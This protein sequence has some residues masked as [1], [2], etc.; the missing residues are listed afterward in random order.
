MKVWKTLS[1]YLMKVHCIPWSFS[2]SKS[3]GF[4]EISYRI[5]SFMTEIWCFTRIS[6][7][8]T[9][10]SMENF[11]SFQTDIDN[12]N[13]YCFLGCLD[14][15]FTDWVPWQLFWSIKA[16]NALKLGCVVK[17]RKLLVTNFGLYLPNFDFPDVA[18][19]HKAL[20]LLAYWHY[21][22]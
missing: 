21:A 20:R 12:D 9:L 17:H 16:K 10:L 3:L 13:S 4:Y 6:Q 2:W 14:T 5:A 19:T 8:L 18:S 15:P 1:R 22:P 11:L 7:I